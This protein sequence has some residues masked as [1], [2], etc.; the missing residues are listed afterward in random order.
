MNPM[1][2]IK[3]YQS[4]Q[5]GALPGGPGPAA[6]G[7]EFG[8]ILDGVM[9]GAIEQTRAAETQMS[10]AV[11]GLGSLIDGVPAVS[12]AEATLEPG[13]AVRDQVI[14]AYQEIMRMPI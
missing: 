12:S 9:K 2:A 13:M 11:Q 4:V 3:A 1:D 14:Q 5:T 10:L 7:G 8:A 6:E